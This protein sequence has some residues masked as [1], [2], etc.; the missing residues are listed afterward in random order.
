MYINR[1]TSLNNNRKFCG[2]TYY[3]GEEVLSQRIHIDD[4]GQGDY[5]V[6]IDFTK[7][8]IELNQPFCK[9][10]T[11]IISRTCFIRLNSE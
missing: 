4:P 5:V 10:I 6:R 1:I 8:E 3:E 9:G 7:D 2:N 11:E